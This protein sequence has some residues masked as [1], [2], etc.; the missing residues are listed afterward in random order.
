VLWGKW[1]KAP[2]AGPEEE[3]R[4]AVGEDESDR[5]VPVVSR[6]K[7]REG[8]GEGR[9]RGE[10]FSGWLARLVAPGWPS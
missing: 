9:W 7:K 4:G 3:E 6:K 5:W 1:G 8:K 2:G 10:V